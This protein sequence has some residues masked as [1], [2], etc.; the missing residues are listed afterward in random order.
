MRRGILVL[1]QVRQVPSGTLNA[2]R[3]E[4]EAIFSHLKAHG[5]KL[6]FIHDLPFVVQEQHKARSHSWPCAARLSGLEP[7]GQLRVM[8]RLPGQGTL[9]AVVSVIMADMASVIHDIMSH[10]L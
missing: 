5:R 4:Q 1:R 6:F 2:S 9:R 3:L 8:M 10:L 7:A